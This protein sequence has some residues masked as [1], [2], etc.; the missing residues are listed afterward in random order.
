MAGA[1]LTEIGCAIGMSDSDER[2]PQ[3][4]RASDVPDRVSNQDDPVKCVLPVVGLGSGDGG[5]DDLV[6]CRSI[7]G[8]CRRKMAHIEVCRGDL[9]ASR[10]LPAA[11]RNRNAP[12]GMPQPGQKCC[13]AR[14]FCKG[15]GSRFVATSQQSDETVDERL[16]FARI[17]CAT[18]ARLKYGLH[19]PEVRHVLVCRPF[20]IDILATERCVEGLQV[21]SAIDSEGPGQGPV[22]IENNEIHKR[23]QRL[24][25]LARG[26]PPY[27][28]RP[29]EAGRMPQGRPVRFCPT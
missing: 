5:L 18:K 8:E 15:V 21:A 28:E 10:P 19:D 14:Y 20:R 1:K 7:L 4:L 9:E 22:E 3:L 16:N 6:P 2:Q 26:E 13:R 24:V 29:R 25:Q 11:G 23:V 27:R 12:L 17:R